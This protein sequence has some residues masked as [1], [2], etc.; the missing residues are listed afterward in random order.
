MCIFSG[1][2]SRNC[3]Q[4]SDQQFTNFLILKC[5]ITIPF[6][7]DYSCPIFKI[8]WDFPG[9]AVVKN[10]PA[11]QGTWVQALVWEDPIC[12]RATKPTHTTTEPALQSPQPTT[13]EPACLERVLHKKRSHCSE[14]PVHRTEEQ[15]PLAENQR[16]PAHS[17]GDPTQPKNR[18][19][20]KITI[21]EQIS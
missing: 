12:R 13:T 11:M 6:L 17:N 7:G 20:K 8:T 9:G 21:L 15:P 2:P 14:K 10:P 5:F 3:V 19:K 4:E 16:K 1:Y 18:K